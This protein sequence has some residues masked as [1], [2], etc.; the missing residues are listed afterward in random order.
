MR[1]SGGE[2]SSKETHVA[3]RKIDVKLYTLYVDPMGATLNPELL[4]DAERLPPRFAADPH[5]YLRLLRKW[6]RYAPKSA[7]YGGTVIIEMKFETEA[8]NMDW[9]FGVEAAFDSVTSGRSGVEGQG[10]TNGLMANSQISLIAN[11]GDPQVAAAV[12]DFTPATHEA[13]TFRNDLEVWLK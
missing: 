11:G 4:K 10:S 6:G 5:G 9:A 7:S 12:T 13:I 8:N 3:D 2:Q 1:G